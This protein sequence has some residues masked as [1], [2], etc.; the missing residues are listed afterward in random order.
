M[1]HLL[2]VIAPASA[3]RSLAEAMRVAGMR[4]GWLD[5]AGA[6][7]VPPALQEAERLGSLRAVAVGDGRSVA[8]KPIAGAPVLRDLVREH[9]LGCQLVLCR[10][11]AEEMPRL[12]PAGEDW[13]LELPGGRTRRRSTAELVAD[14]RRPS[15]WPGASR[16]G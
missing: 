1:P 11:G 8:V 9:F 4:L 5:R 12:E 7:V 14:L 15:P 16:Q 10:G 6:A 13:M 2:R 3:Y